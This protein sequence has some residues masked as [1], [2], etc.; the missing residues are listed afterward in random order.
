MFT[1]KVVVGLAECVCILWNGPL[2]CHVT[3]CYTELILTYLL[4]E[5]SPS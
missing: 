5:L 3:E 4:T 1:V 2:Q